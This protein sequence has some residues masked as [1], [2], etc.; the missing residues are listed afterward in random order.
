MLEF[1]KVLILTPVKSA[2]GYLPRYVELIEALDW[3]VQ[4]LSLGILEGD[5]HDD[6]ADALDGLRERL[7]SRCARVT[8]SHHDYGYA[9]PPSLHRWVPAYQ[10]VRRKIIAR[11]RNRLLFSALR[12]E[13]WVLWIDVD[14]VDYPPDLIQRLMAPGFDIVTPHAVTMPGG[15]SFDANS[16]TDGGRK[17]LQHHRGAGAVRL[18]GVGGTILMIKA[19]LHRDGLVFPP[20]PYGL[21]NPRIR[22]VA[23]DWGQGEIETE[24]LGMMAADM[25][26]Q[27]WGL[28]DFEVYHRKTS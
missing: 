9:S 10:M 25:G 22:E 24:G 16:W 18:D 6:T 14:M 23:G 26:V 28:P 8:I 2:S 19:D 4:R 12:D 27:C 15:G 11:A 3:P 20:F 21:R 7:E 5:S 17:L 13:D 1:P